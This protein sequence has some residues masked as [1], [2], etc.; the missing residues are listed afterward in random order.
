MRP[1]R[2]LRSKAFSRV[3]MTVR[4]LRP[5]ISMEIVRKESQSKESTEN[6][7]RQTSLKLRR[8]LTNEV[9]KRMENEARF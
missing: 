6:V 1:S 7:N 5:A 8:D 2:I 3:I 9:S 4:S